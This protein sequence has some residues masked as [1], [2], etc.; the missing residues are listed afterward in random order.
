[1]GYIGVFI[2][3]HL[4]AAH[5]DPYPDYIYLTGSAIIYLGLAANAQIPDYALLNP[6]LLAALRLTP[7]IW[8]SPAGMAHSFHVRCLPWIQFMRPLNSLLLCWKNVTC[9]FRMRLANGIVALRATFHEK[10]LVAHFQ[11]PLPRCATNRPRH[12][13]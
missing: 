2:R 9:S 5:R 4:S 10:S 3:L 7:L 8:F 1:L 6:G 13:R 11:S 12:K